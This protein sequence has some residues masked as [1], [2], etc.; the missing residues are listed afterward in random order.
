MSGDPAG[1]AVERFRDRLRR[2]GD[3]A[4]A[5]FRAETRLVEGFHAEAEVRG[6]RLTIDEPAA[7]GGSDRGPNPV[8]VLLAALGTCQEIVYAL[9]ARLLGIA[10]DAVT[11][12]VTGSIDPR[13]FYGVAEVP[14]GLRAVSFAVDLRSPADPAEIE[15]LIAAVNDHCPVL[16]SLRRP[17][18][19]A[20]RYHHNGRPVAS[21]DQ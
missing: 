15:R 6:F 14:A 3:T 10:L 18:P 11:V 17:V 7:V 9:Y 16:D 12:T 19:V 4:Q 13:G 5:S 20:G 8:E 2:V 1:A 21:A